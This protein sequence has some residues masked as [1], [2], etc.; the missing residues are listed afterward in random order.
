MSMSVVI[1]I[2]F[3]EGEYQWMPTIIFKI[4][5]W[6]VTSY[7]LL[8]TTTTKKENALWIALFMDLSEITFEFNLKLF[9]VFCSMLDLT[10]NVKLKIYY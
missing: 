1:S 6:N 9:I 2:S 4:N 5:I 10:W 8:Y 3:N 7:I